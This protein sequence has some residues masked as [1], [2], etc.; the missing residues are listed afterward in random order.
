MAWL[1]FSLFLIPWAV[2]KCAANSCLD[3]LNGR[4][5]AEVHYL[6]RGR[7]FSEGERRS[8][9]R[10]CSEETTR[11]WSRHFYCNCCVTL[12]W[13][14]QPFS[15]RERVREKEKIKK[16]HDFLL[17]R[18]CVLVM[19]CF[20]KLLMSLTPSPPLSLSHTLPHFKFP[21]ISG[22]G[23]CVCVR[24]SVSRPSIFRSK[25]DNSHRRRE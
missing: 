1:G 8:R 18:G 3:R 20:K 23:L 6:G 16:K 11:N 5:N 14:C 15:A 21:C 19:W 9:S 4:C 7:A 25:I 2:S 22:S 17:K 10:S 24:G 12:V 13:S